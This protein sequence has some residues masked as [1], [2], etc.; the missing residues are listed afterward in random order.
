MRIG[1]LVELLLLLAKGGENRWDAFFKI[2]FKTRIQVKV[3]A[4]SFQFFLGFLLNWQFYFWNL[5]GFGM[6]KDK[7]DLLNWYRSSTKIVQSGHIEY[8]KYKKFTI[9]RKC[10][11]W[12]WLR[13]MAAF[14]G[15]RLI[16]RCVASESA[17]CLSITQYNINISSIFLLKTRH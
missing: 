17:F 2:K 1:Q 7:L 4:V 16:R 9:Y 8:S 11:S 6:D 15:T 14:R 12:D 13:S 10:I 5:L 3:F